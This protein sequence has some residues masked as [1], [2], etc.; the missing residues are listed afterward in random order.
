MSTVVSAD[1]CASL[2][3]DQVNEVL[4]IAASGAAKGPVHPDAKDVIKDQVKRLR[5]WKDQLPSEMV[6]GDFVNEMQAICNFCATL[7]GP[8]W[9]AN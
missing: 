8:R 4:R 6:F 7:K 1:V 3:D 9:A 2:I 5:A